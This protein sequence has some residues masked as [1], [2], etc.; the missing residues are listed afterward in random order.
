M[1]SILDGMPIEN[2]VCMKTDFVFNKCYD[3][4]LTK[5]T[6]NNIKEFFKELGINVLPTTIDLLKSNL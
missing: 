6:K 4:G 5:Y 1:N 3:F 2:M